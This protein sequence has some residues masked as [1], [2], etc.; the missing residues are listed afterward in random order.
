MASVTDLTPPP[1]PVK[2]AEAI[3]LD[4]CPSC[5]GKLT[6]P[7][8]L[9]WCPKCGYCREVEREKQTDSVEPAQETKPSFLGW[10]ETLDLV[11]DLPPWFW[12]MVAGMIVI[13]GVSL[14]TRWFLGPQS[15][16]RALWCTVQLILGV[17][18]FYT[19]QVWAWFKLA[20]KDARLGVFDCFLSARLWGQVFKRMPAMRWQVWIGSWGL[21]L[22]LC[23]LLVVGGLT[24]WLKGLPKASKQEQTGAGD[25][26]APAKSGKSLEDAVKELAQ[27]GSG[28]VNKGEGEEENKEFEPE[29][30][31]P[32]PI[33]HGIVIGYVPGGEGKVAE[34]VIAEVNQGQLRYVGLCS[35]GPGLKRPPRMLTPRKP[36]AAA[37]QDEPNP[38]WEVEK[39]RREQKRKERHAKV[40]EQLKALPQLASL[41]PAIT[42]LTIK[43]VWVRPEM[44][45]RFYYSGYDMDGLVI[46]AELKELDPPKKA[47]DEEAPAAGQRQPEEK[48]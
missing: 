36:T 24:N 46:E 42:G 22:V 14:S 40:E 6:N 31:D 28:F 39:A 9:G 29:P 7:E 25:P 12:V 3:P 45:A 48:P 37:D 23:A 8:G 16:T 5:K 2:T 32:R 26:A 47:L 30:E 18:L 4:Q 15:R 41:D 35:R 10:R 1:A 19:G 11:R 43:A 17:L 38:A 34:L 20:P 21:T 13:L 44:M 27:T 33:L